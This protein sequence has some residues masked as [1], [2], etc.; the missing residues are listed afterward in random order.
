MLQLPVLMRR[1][2]FFVLSMQP[3][4]WSIVLATFNE[5]SIYCSQKNVALSI[6]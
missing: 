2:Y 4:G 3:A 1:N 6:F 5:I